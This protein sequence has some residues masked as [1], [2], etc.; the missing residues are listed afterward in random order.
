MG[1]RRRPLEDLGLSSRPP[2][3]P[4]PIPPAPA[5]PR[6][7]Y[8]DARS[9]HRSRRLHRHRPRPALPG[10]RP[11][12]RRARQRSC[13]P[14]CVFGD[15]VAPVPAIRKDLRDV[16]PHDFEGFDA[17]VNL[18]ALSNDPLGDL[19]PQCTYDINHHG[20]VI[21]AK[22]AK[23]AG[24]PRFLM[25]SSCSLYGAHGDAPDRRVGRVQP[26]DAL[27]RVEGAVGAGHLDAGR[28]RLPPDVPAQRHRLRRVAPPARRPRGEQPRGLRPDDRRGPHEVRRH[29]VASARAHRGHRAGVP[30]HARG[31]ASTSCTTR[32]QRRPQ[33]RELPDPRRRQ[34]RRGDRPRLEGRPSRAAPSPTSATTA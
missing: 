9:R 31:A 34:D 8:L 20:S 3:P 24:V 7:I 32:V 5:H 1:R 6:R 30:G 26:G 23:E 10:R 25:S 21:A 19:N 13:S 16:T 11:R 2:A 29:A 17:V 33:H 15:D 22:A 27:R 28:R 12:C 18:A 4:A 14:S